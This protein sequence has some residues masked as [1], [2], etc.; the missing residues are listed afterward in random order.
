VS[1]GVRL[2]VGFASRRSP[3]RSRHAPSQKMPFCRAFIVLDLRTDTGRASAVRADLAIVVSC[4]RMRSSEVG[5]VGRSRVTSSD[6][7]ACHAGGRGF[8]SRRSRPCLSL[9]DAAF[10]TYVG[11]AWRHVACPTSALILLCYSRLRKRMSCSR[12]VGC[13]QVRQRPARQRRTGLEQE[14]RLGRRQGGRGAFG[15]RRSSVRKA[16]VQVTS[17]VWWWK[18]G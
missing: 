18:P 6:E 10:A 3:V 8:E 12:S 5:S 17:A 16:W 9:Q 2:S 11:S 4:G 1:G 15:S 14:R 7:S 13:R